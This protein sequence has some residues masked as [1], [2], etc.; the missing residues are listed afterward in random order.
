MSAVPG[1]D[2]YQAEPQ[3]VPN[4]SLRLLWHNHEVQLAAHYLRDGYERKTVKERLGVDGERLKAASALATYWDTK[5]N[6]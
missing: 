3:A 4:A 2:T 5:E 6:S 1:S